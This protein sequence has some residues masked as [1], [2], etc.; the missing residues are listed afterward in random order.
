MRHALILG[1][2]LSTSAA[3][4]LATP[5]VWDQHW[6]VAGAPDI[7]VVADDAHVR[8]HAGP[9][10]AVTAKVSYELKRWGLL[11]G[12][13]E[14]TV[15]FEHQGDHITITA[16]DPKAFGVIGGVDESYVV[17]VT[18][19]P[20]VTLNVR[21]RDGAIDC[22]PLA[23][24]FAFRSGDGAIRGHGLKG[25]I[26]YSSGD[27]RITLDDLDGKLT[28]RAGDGSAKITGRF[29]LID[30]ASADGRI[31]I[32]ARKGSRATADWSLETAD[33]ALNLRIPLDF[34][35]LLDAR[36]RDGSLHMNLPID[37]GRTGHSHEML[38]ELNGGGPRL[39]MRTADGGLTIGVS[40]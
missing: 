19:P 6:T 37:T 36:T 39:R 4:A 28:G 5:K 10:G 24:T 34:A 1:L 23:G 26:D 8:I 17:E 2:L 15:V 40:E 9:A 31:E 25:A 18:V 38:G 20:T 12:G 11:V 14:P 29:D 32:D 13:G 16:H 30:V 33:G 35:A 21:T 7:K 22:D 27:G 3:S